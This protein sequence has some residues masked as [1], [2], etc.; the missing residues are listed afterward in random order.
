[1]AKF[2]E[3]IIEEIRGRNT[4]VINAILDIPA[5]ESIEQLQ[6]LLTTIDQVIPSITNNLHDRTLT[7]EEI[8]AGGKKN[9]F[10]NKIIEKARTRPLL[11]AKFSPAIEQE[12]GNQNSS[13]INSILNIPEVE[14]QQQFQPL[15]TAIAQV[16]P[17][18]TNNL[19]D[20]TLTIFENR[21]GG[22]KN[23]LITSII[24][25]SQTNP[26]L[27]KKFSSLITQEIR[28]MN[29]RIINQI[30]SRSSYDGEEH[31]SLL[32]VINE[33]ISPISNQLKSSSFKDEELMRLIDQIVKNLQTNSDQEFLSG[34]YNSMIVAIENS[35]LTTQE[36][37][38]MLKL[39]LLTNNA[40]CTTEN[41]G[42]KQLLQQLSLEQKLNL[43]EIPQGQACH[44]NCIKIV[45]NGI[46]Q[47]LRS[48][49][50]TDQLCQTIVFNLPGPLP[51]ES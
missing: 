38:E 23:Y 13:V 21:A 19:N 14:S 12:I 48:T 30:L 43:L 29:W 34:L 27:F 3:T 40:V 44:H 17:S 45:V 41:Q 32:A 25:R 7:R 1:M 15:L 24:E 8:M 5:I 6:P 47:E 37:T 36:K 2:P 20:R 28:A 11:L 49:N 26:L 50:I 16:I 39:I 18:I 10:I 42:L 46:V 4:Q 22:K 33:F 31:P 51:E 35:T 9:Y